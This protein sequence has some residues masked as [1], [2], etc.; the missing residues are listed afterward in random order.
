MIGTSGPSIS[1]MTLST[2]RP[3]ER[4]HQMLDG[5]DR[6]AGRIADDGAEVG[7]ADG[8][9]VGRDHRGRGRR[10]GR[11]AGRRCRYRLRP[12]AASSRPGAPEWTPTPVSSSRGPRAS[13]ACP[14]SR[15]IP[16]PRHAVVCSAARSSTRPCDSLPLRPAPTAWIAMRRPAWLDAPSRL[17]H[18]RNIAAA[19]NAPNHAFLRF[20]TLDRSNSR[21]PVTIS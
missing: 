10:R 5:G 16:I 18:D 4:R 6:G 19:D 8:A 15:L 11:S 2:P 17:L 13:S 1:T 9:V 12:G 3:R 14:D 7:R 21:D 20:V